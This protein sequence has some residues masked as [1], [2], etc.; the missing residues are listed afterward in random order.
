MSGEEAVQAGGRAVLYERPLAYAA[1]LELQERLHAARCRDEIPDTVLVLQHQPVITLG[2]RGRTQHLHAGQDELRA[3]GVELYTASRGGDV[4]YHGPGQWVLYPI[5][6]LTGRAAGAHGYLWNLEET[7][8]RTAGAF[9]VTAY[10]REGMNGAWTASGKIAAIG[11]HVRRGVTLHGMSF[12]VRAALEGFE[13]ITPCGL[14]GE[15]VAGLETLLGS[16]C[17]SMTEVARCLVAQFS[18]VMGQSFTLRPST[19]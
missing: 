1:A 2:R 7:A 3:R 16:G 8:I 11:F 4:T 14:E 19:D 9:G 17:T 15:Q 12:N 18:A 10:R 13:W 5:L 6:R